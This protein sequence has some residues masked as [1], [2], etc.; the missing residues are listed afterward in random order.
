MVNVMVYV[1]AEAAA[2]NAVVLFSPDKLNFYWNG[3]KF[4]TLNPEGFVFFVNKTGRY[5]LFTKLVKKDIPATSPAPDRSIFEDNGSPYEVSNEYPDFVRFS[6]MDKVEIPN[7][8]W[9]WTT[10]GASET[11]YF[12]QDGIPPQN[13]VRTNNIERI[14][15]LAQLFDN[16]HT[17][18]HSLLMECRE[19]LSNFPPAPPPPQNP[20]RVIP[21]QNIQVLN[22]MLNLVEYIKNK[23]FHFEP[24]QI[25]CYVTALRTKPFVILAGV[26]GTGKSKLPALVAEATGGFAR[27]IPVRPDWTDSAEVIGYSDLQNNFRPGQLLQYI[28]V[29]QKAENVS[30][31]HVCIIDEM[32]LARVEHYFAEVLSRIEDREKIANGYQSKQLFSGELKLEDRCWGEHGI[33]PN[34]AIVGTVN[35]DESTHGFSKKVLDRAF[36]IELSDVDLDLRPTA[37]D[38]EL[39]VPWPLE[40]WQPRA[41]RLGELSNLTAGE[42]I[43]IG[44][45][46]TSLKQI[47]AILIQAQLQ[48][49]YRTRDEIA[50]FVIH[51]QESLEFFK[52]EIGDIID[53]LDLALMMKILPRIAG[54]SSPVRTSVLGLL[55]WAY[56]GEELV[57]EKDAEPLLEKWKSSGQAG[58]LP[59]AKFPRTAAKLCLMLDRLRND[60]F[61]SFWL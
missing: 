9:Q 25:A 44:N 16:N 31:Q 12:R 40:K 26:S 38:N 14:D 20:P 53:P 42:N 48:V 43:L 49:G 50:L 27:L 18:A 28:A 1:I 2:P 24:W 36:T 60:G 19:H 8:N 47:N 13:N 11:T 6:I 59:D 21:N 29:A 3:K 54:G 7:N 23:G 32:N 34:L 46:I 30:T 61:T 51:A 35:M 41:I 55:G 58:V 17:D 15:Q 57:S 33:T 45:V 4:R 56:N 52:T 5:V 39:P 10:L 22:P 37:T